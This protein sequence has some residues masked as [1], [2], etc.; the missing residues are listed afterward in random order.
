M[1]LKIKDVLV[2]TDNQTKAGIHGSV[3]IEI[4]GT[5][6]MPIV[7]V[8]NITVKKNKNGEMFLSMPA[9]KNGDKYYN[10]VDLF[11]LSDNE[12]NNETQ[13]KLR[14]ELT[15]E[16]IRILEAGGT[17]RPAKTNTPPAVG[18]APAKGKFPWEQ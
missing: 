4:T 8:N 17:K 7:T 9:Y 5:D 3:T 2:P 12:A 10:Y 13:K 16:V 6:N 11:K 14:S 1:Q 18:T 15:K